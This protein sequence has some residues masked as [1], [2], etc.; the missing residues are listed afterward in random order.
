MRKIV[1]LMLLVFALSTGC[2]TTYC[3]K[4]YKVLSSYGNWGVDQQSSQFIKHRNIC[5]RQ[6]RASLGASRD[7]FGF[8]GC[9]SESDIR[10]EDEMYKDCMEMHG[11]KLQGISDKM[12][13]KPGYN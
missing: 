4:K 10:I 3:V 11:Y 2:S 6:A 13:N 7:M 9:L 12:L 8:G 1:W 5:M